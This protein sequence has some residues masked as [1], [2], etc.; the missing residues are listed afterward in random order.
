MPPDNVDRT[1]KA[2]SIMMAVVVSTS[3]SGRISTGFFAPPAADTR[4][5]VGSSAAVN[6]FGNPVEP[7]KLIDLINGWS[8]MPFTM[9]APPCTMLTTPLET[10][11]QKFEQFD[12]GNR[13]AAGGFDHN[14]IA[15][16]NRIRK[17]PEGDHGREVERRDNP[18]HAQWL[19]DHD[20]VNAGGDILD[21]I[22]HH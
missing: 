9:S 12:H 4:F 15:C 8:S 18:H 3:A 10:C 6:M 16:C 13:H 11:F 5:P 22:T 21:H 19:A 2:L 1:A 20:L 7:T 14:R 17:K